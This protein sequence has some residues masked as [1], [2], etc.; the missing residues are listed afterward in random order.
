MEENN[1]RVQEAEE[2]RSKV[3]DR[4]VETFDMEQKREAKLKRNEDRLRELLDHFKCTN[5][6]MIGMP[7]IEGEKVPEGIFEEIIAK[8]FPNLG[9]ESFIQ[10]QEA[11]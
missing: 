1:S 11:Q 10:I 7:E 8:N 4:L 3:E 9:K 2:C 6:C 5:I